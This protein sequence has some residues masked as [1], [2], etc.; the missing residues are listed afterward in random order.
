MATEAL[1]LV[2][3]TAEAMGWDDGRA[4]CPCGAEMVER[5]NAGVLV[6]RDPDCNTAALVSGG[7][8]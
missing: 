5:D 4:W 3:V 7:Q 6:C 1:E 2:E 8:S